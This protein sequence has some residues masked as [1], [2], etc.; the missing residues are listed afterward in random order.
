MMIIDALDHSATTIDAHLPDADIFA[1][2]G[3]AQRDDAAR[4]TI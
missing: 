2:R 1:M 4:V 3:A